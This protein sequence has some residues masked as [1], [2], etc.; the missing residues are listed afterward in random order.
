MIWAFVIYHTVLCQM[1]CYIFLFIVVTSAA[2]LYGQ[3]IT[4]K[5]VEDIFADFGSFWRELAHEEQ[6][7]WVRS[8]F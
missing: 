4:G 3:M 8:I 5:C 6:L 7:R 1:D 2:K